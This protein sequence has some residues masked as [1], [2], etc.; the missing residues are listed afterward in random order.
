MPRGNDG[1]AA[2]ADLASQFG[3]FDNAQDLIDANRASYPQALRAAS[4]QPLNAEATK[5]LLADTSK[6]E[7]KLDDGE[8]VAEGDGAIAVRGN[9]VVVVVSDENGRL[10]KRVFGH[11]E[12]GGPKN[13]KLDVEESE[14]ERSN[15]ERVQR[16]QGLRV[17]VAEATQ[18]ADEKAQE[19][20][21]SAEE[22]SQKDIEKARQKAEKDK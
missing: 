18:Q 21:E 10:S 14:E 7:S 9:A 19:A 22:K 20:R 4:M 13:A 6:V 1:A 5:E 2:Q 17:A 11:A 15:R 8:S 12:V 16:R 3:Q